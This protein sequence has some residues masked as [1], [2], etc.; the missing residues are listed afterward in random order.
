MGRGEGGQLERK[1]EVREDKWKEEEGVLKI[2]YSSSSFNQNLIFRR[3][4]KRLTKHVGAM[5]TGRLTR[6]RLG[7]PNAWNRSLLIL[8]KSYI[9]KLA[10]TSQKIEF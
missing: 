4:L 6:E 10:A 7:P 1:E 9:N 2:Y 8:L 5:S 3:L